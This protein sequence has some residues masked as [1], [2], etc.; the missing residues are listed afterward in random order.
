MIFL[1]KVVIYL[2]KSRADEEAE[3]RGEGET[4]IKHK[5]ALLKLANQ[6]NINIIKIYEEIASGES[7]MHRPEMLQLLKEVEENTYDAVLVMDM[8]RLGRGNMQ[9]QG[10]I[11]ETFKKSKTKIITPRK[12][13]DLE[14]EFDEEY[15]EFEAFMARKELKIITRRLQSGRIRSVEEGNYIGTLPP[16]GYEIEYRDNNRIRT[17]KPHPEQ[18]EIV[19]LIFDLYTNNSLGTAKI[20]NKLNELGYKT[21]TGKTWSASSVL[22]IIKNKVYAGFVQWKKTEN[23]KSKKVGQVRE[24]RLRDKSEWIEVNGKHEAIISLEIYN[25]AQEILT[26]KYHVPYQL[27]NGISNPLAGIVKCEI[28][29]SSMISR[30]YKHTDNQIMCYNSCGNKGSKLKYVEEKL[31][32]G[33]NDWLISYKKR[34]DIV[35][36]H[37]EN[38]NSNM[39]MYKKIVGGLENELIELEKQKNKLHD[40][41]E[42]GI[43]DVDTYLDR[44]KNLAERI[45]KTNLAIEKSKEALSLEIKKENAQKDIIPTVENV[46]DL[47]SKTNDIEKKNKLLKSV[48]EYALYKKEKWERNEQFTL[49][50]SPKLPN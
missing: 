28:C 32:Q 3:K 41:L 15:S 17:L 24:T 7:L 1:D 39:D 34:W 8:D 11:L 19:K 37:T 5:K 30:P 49:K 2:R 22:V 42:R 46:L 45:E 43:Y 4:L 12:T 21:Y 20:A 48:L 50:L 47:Y 31:I 40:F 36:S 38:I 13:Y 6:L 33:L 29:G 18:S 44:S 25:K 35:D 23:I 9:E 10:L 26:K 16:Y 27:T 14:N